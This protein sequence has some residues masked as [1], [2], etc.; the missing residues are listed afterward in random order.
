LDFG[1]WILNA[2]WREFGR[3]TDKIFPPFLPQLHRLLSPTPRYSTFTTSLPAINIFRR[4]TD[5]R[6][7]LAACCLPLRLLSFKDGN[8]GH[9]VQNHGTRSQ[10][11]PSRRGH[12]LLHPYYHFIIIIIIVVSYSMHRQCSGSSSLPNQ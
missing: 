9:G 2:R 8:H 3:Q 7:L 4:Q 1:F 11:P 5:E 10:S 6:S 12:L